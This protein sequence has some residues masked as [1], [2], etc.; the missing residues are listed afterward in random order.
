MINSK[1]LLSALFAAAC[2][3]TA[4]A[5]DDGG[6]DLSSQRGEKQDVNAVPGKKIDHHGIIVNPTPHNLDINRMQWLDFANGVNIK[7]KQKKFASDLDFLKQNAKGAQFTIDFGEKQAKKAGLKK[8]VSGAYLLKVDAKGISITGYD[9]RGAFYALQTMRQLLASPAAEGKMRLPYLTCNDYPDLPLRGVVEGFYG[10]PWSHQVRL[11]LIDYYG[12][13]KLNEYV[14]GPKDDPYHSS[15][16]W[17]LPYPPEQAKNIHEL[18]E[19]CRRNRVDF[20]W[21][22]HPGKDIKWNEEDYN[23]L[24]NK[25]NLMYELG[26]RSFAIHFDDIDGEGTNPKKQ[27]E[28]LNRLTRE[29]V[30]TKGDVAPLVVCPTDYSQLWAKPGPD[31]PL[32]IY[33]N[34]L[35]PSI[36]VFWTGA[37][38]C[39]DLTK[40]TLDFVDS[41]IKRPAYYWWNFPVTD[42]ARHIIMQGPSYGLGNDITDEMTCGVLS[43]P[44]EHGEASKLA[45]YGV[46]DYNWNVADYNPID[47]WERGLVDLTPE[48]HD[49]YRTFAIHSCDTETGYRRDESWETK[50]F[51]L[52]DFSQKAYDD[53]YAEFD[54][55]EKVKKTME[56]DCKNQL[57]MKE[58]KPWLT[59]FKKLG[60]RGKHTLELMQMFRAGNDQNFW[61]AYIQNRM[62]KDDRAAYEKHK[63]GTMVL[64]P[65]YE[66][67]MDD[68]ATE[69]FKKLTGEVP[70]LY[71]GVGS[72]PTLST[73][74]NKLMFDNDS[75]T[76][77]HCGRS[78]ETGDWVGADLG[79]V[80]K[81]SEVKILQG[82]NSV[83][84]VDYFDN[85]VLEA[86][87]D[88]KSW[89]KLTGDLAKTYIIHWK[90]EPVEAR[91]VRIRKLQSEKKS[92]IAV[93][94]FMVNPT[95]PES[96]PFKVC[97]NDMEAAMYGF[98]SNPCTSF[99]NNGKLSFDVMSA[100]KGYTMLLNVQPNTVVKFNQYDKRGKLIAS[101]PIDNSYFT[102]TLTK[103]AVKAEIEGNVEVFEV[104]ANK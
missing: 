69:F 14:Y 5:Q 59:E 22:I 38:V 66:N 48:A 68:M 1:Y 93:R 52:A 96:L 102:T 9:E 65:F 103:G 94:E 36:N 78:Q 74:Q 62:S 77:Y 85:T 72:Y 43:N 29:F 104:I 15:P 71:K 61:N 53:L 3:C 50:T 4:V 40:E 63:S 26:V 76:Y 88:G 7:D 31:G 21:A 25:F 98:D 95:T 13:N 99:V 39:S 92:W 55:V 91:Y 18:V 57:L 2:C 45:L 82:R 67:A 28:L 84:D 89:Q 64:Q 23:N 60:E 80:R 73:T 11:S 20:V 97:A 46:A 24:V 41:R 75:T 44:M 90:G 19:A 6:F 101:T 56:R 100:T 35:D 27:V 79:M 58:L 81:V 34:E 37:V 47:N 33:G 70:A 8:L 54:R 87:V 32:A 49:A 17:R 42:Y 30:K 83:D 51:R 10:E 16:N 86:S 12:R